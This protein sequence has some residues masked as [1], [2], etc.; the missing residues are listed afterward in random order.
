M[1]KLKPSPLDEKLF[2]YSV[3]ELMKPLLELE[4]KGFWHMPQYADEVTKALHLPFP[5]ASHIAMTV[6]RHIALRLTDTFEKGA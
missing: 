1:T 5:S 6:Y 2:V 4:Q 3:E